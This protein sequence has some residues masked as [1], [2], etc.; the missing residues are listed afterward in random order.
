MKYF[1][2]L[3]FCATSCL[4]FCQELPRAVKKV[5]P[6]LFIN[7]IEN[8]RVYQQANIRENLVVFSRSFESRQLEAIQ[9][10]FHY[11]FLDEKNKNC[12][13][14]F[15]FDRHDIK[16]HNGLNME[17]VGCNDLG[18]KIYAKKEGKWKDCTMEALPNDFL[19]V[20]TQYLQTLQKSSLGMYFYN[21]NPEQAV[22]MSLEKNKLIFRQ[23]GKVKL[24]LIWKKGAFVW[25]CKMAD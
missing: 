6:S 20:V 15:Q 23:N 4:T 21:Q 3:L 17:P 10:S 24:S 1:F 9:Q 11:S 2:I 13:L 19:I 8:E 22:S 25:K 12:L 18:F 16:L 7:N 14:E 5:N